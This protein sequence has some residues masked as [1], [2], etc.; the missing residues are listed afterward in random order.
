MSDTIKLF[1]I[2]VFCIILSLMPVSYEGI[3]GTPYTV[4][5]EEKT[6]AAD[7][8]IMHEEE[9]GGVYIDL[10][11]DEFNALGFAYG[12]SV[13]IVFSNG[14]Q[15]LDIPYYNG[16]YTPN[17]EPLLIAYPGYSHIKACI[18]NCY[19]DSFALI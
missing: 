4:Q 1:V 10:T 6:A 5:S 13:D 2:G 9:F 19:N 14:F 11:T 12:D 7:L 18:N 3:S 8:G 16:Y 15:L 17:G